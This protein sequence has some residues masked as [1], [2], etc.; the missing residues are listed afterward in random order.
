MLITNP[1]GA[2][3]QHHMRATAASSTPLRRAPLGRA[4]WRRPGVA[5]SSSGSIRARITRLPL[6]L[7]PSP[8]HTDHFS[9]RQWSLHGIWKR[10]RRW[11]AGQLCSR[12]LRLGAVWDWSRVGHGTWGAEPAL[13]AVGARQALLHRMQARPAAADP[14]SRQPHTPP[15]TPV[16]SHTLHR[17]PQSA[18]THST[19]RPSRQPHT[20]PIAP[21]CPTSAQT[22]SCTR[23]THQMKRHQLARQP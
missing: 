21:V 1:A 17:T 18:A 20:P 23:R 8:L 5:L 19:G 7:A 10:L 22:S 15:N 3:H 13:A 14:Y 11:G 16:G 4:A 2:R 6:G 9:I 12:S